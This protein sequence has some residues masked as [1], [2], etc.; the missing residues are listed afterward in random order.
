MKLNPD[1]FF[2]INYADNQ[3]IENLKIK[4]LQGGT[5]VQYNNPTELDR[6]ARNAILEYHVNIQGVKE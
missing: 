2:M 1:K 6:I 5:G 3:S 4:L